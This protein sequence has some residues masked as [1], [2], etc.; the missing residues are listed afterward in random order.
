ML[1]SVQSIVVAIS[2]VIARSAISCVEIDGRSCPSDYRERRTSP[3]SQWENVKTS[4]H[5]DLKF[6]WFKEN[7]RCTLH[8]FKQMVPEIARAWV[9]L[10]GSNRHTS[11]YGIEDH[12]ALTLH[13][14]SHSGSIKLTAN[15]FGI[16]KSYTIRCVNRMVRVLKYMSHSKISLP[17]ASEWERLERGMHAIAGFPGAVLAIDGS[18]LEIER[19][20]DH[21]GWYCRKGYPAINMQVVVDYTGKVRSYSLRPGSANDKQLYN[22]SSFKA[23]ITRILPLN[24]HILGDAGYKLETYLLIPYPITDC[25]SHEEKHYN[26]V[27]SRTRIVIER[28]FGILKARFRIFKSP[29]NQKTEE[30]KA[31]MIIATLVLHNM[32][33]ELNDVTVD[34]NASDLID[35]ETVFVGDEEHTTIE[36]L[37]KRDHIKNIL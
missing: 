27:H 22:L 30:G 6:N 18:L 36:A 29:L 1:N 37:Q 20:R 9:D 31:N 17:D 14:I 15:L 25:M 35:E 13:Y 21:E 28:T 5:D 8:S 10:Y 3:I 2:M 16:S 4:P 19:P 33:V 24:Y 7:L 11:R 26:Y 12:F 34:I 32:L 23:N